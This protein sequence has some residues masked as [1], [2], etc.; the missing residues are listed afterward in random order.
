MIPISMNFVSVIL[1][2]IKILANRLVTSESVP[3][4]WFSSSMGA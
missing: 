3:K 4:G 1:D 2:I